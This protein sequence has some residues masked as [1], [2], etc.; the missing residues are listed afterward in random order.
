MRRMLAALLLALT[1]VVLTQMPAHACTCVRSNTETH[2]KNAS[3]IFVGTVT[4]VH[5]KK[6]AKTL[7]YDVDVEKIFKGTVSDPVTLQS[8]TNVD[9]CALDDLLADHRYLIF[10]T[11]QGGLVEVNSCGGSEPLSPTL[12]QQVVKVL[13][14][15]TIPGATEP[16]PPS[17]ATFERVDDDE[18]TGF[19]RLA[20]PGGA[21]VIVGLLG[22]LLLRR[23]TRVR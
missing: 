15:G 11:A 10:G 1:G 4:A 13:G 20:A 22:L 17:E 12:L 2:I 7:T 8:P 23:V 16:E 14:N 6:G 5:K 9:K 21:L 19:G 3:A 18:P